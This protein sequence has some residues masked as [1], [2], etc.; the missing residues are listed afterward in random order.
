MPHREGTGAHSKVVVHENVVR[1]SVNP[2]TGRK[3]I[4][5]LDAGWRSSASP[6]DRPVTGPSSPATSLSRRTCGAE[7]AHNVGGGARNF[8]RSCGGDGNPRPG[9]PPSPRPGRHRAAF[10][11]RPCAKAQVG[12]KNAVSWLRREGT[13]RPLGQPAIPNDYPLSALGR[14]LRSAIRS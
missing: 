13:G 10:S 9:F 5:V 8:I 3:E 2:E 14:R 11:A 12:Q 1:R 4:K 7:S 6:S